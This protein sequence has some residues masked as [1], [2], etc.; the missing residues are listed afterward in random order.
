MLVCF[1][2]AQWDFLN[3]GVNRAKQIKVHAFKSSYR[4]VSPSSTPAV[5]LYLLKWPPPYENARKNRPRQLLPLLQRP[6]G[7]QATLC[8]AMVLPGRKSG[9]RAA[10]R[11]DSSRET[12]GLRP[13]GGPIL[14]FSR[15]ESGEIRRGSPISGPEALL[16]NIG[17]LEPKLTI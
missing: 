12:A 2:L 4:T 17:L 9:F 11:P 16:R 3:L 6:R 15:L 7:A 14:R 10:F 5:A 8:Y 1:R 13:A